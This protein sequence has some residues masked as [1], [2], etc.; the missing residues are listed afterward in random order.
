MEKFSERLIKLNESSLSKLWRKYKDCDSGT[1]SAC[2]Y[3]MTYKEKR[4]ATMRL[5]TDLIKLGYSVTAVSGTFK[6]NFKKPDERLVHERSFIVF[7]RYNEKNLEQDLRKLGEKYD[8]DSITFNNV[9]DGEYVL[10]GTNKTGYPGYGV[11]VRLGR[12][13][14]GED[15]EFF[16]EIHNRPFVF[17]SVD[18]GYTGFDCTRHN[19]NISTNMCLSYMPEFVL[20]E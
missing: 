5:K 4:L 16:S 14:F 8:Q 19:Y 3:Y 12:L 11:V 20:S 6:E 2:R 1:I 13:M 15:G 7:D 17:K 10:I 18:E 9:K